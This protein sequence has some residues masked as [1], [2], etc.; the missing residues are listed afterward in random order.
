[1]TDLKA[2]RNTTATHAKGIEGLNESHVP[3]LFERLKDGAVSSVDVDDA[4]RILSAT[5][6][7]PGGG[8]Y[9][10]SAEALRDAI[11]AQ[12][13]AQGVIEN[14]AEW[15]TDS[16]AAGSQPAAERE[17]TG[18]PTRGLFGEGRLGMSKGERK[19]GH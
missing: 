14:A 15:F 10:Q 1:M 13:D 7:M 12:L 19:G 18:A 9:R 11:V 5:S 16:R 4:N 17:R 3:G 6:T 8:A 2:L